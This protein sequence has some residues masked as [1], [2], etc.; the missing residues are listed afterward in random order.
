MHTKPH[1]HA[2]ARMRART[3]L[4]YTSYI[5]DDQGHLLLCCCLKSSQSYEQ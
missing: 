5:Q 3:Q 4:V 1:T 2:R